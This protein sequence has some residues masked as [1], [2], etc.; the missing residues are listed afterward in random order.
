MDCVYVPSFG[1]TT[2]PYVRGRYFAKD[3]RDVTEKGV[4]YLMQLYIS[5][6]TDAGTEAPVPTTASQSAARASSPIAGYRNRL[7]FSAIRL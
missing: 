6:F 1:I 2:S 3:R 4:A 7:R 5:H